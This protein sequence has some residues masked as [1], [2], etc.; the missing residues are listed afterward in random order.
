MSI[1]FILK[2]Y[3]A[4]S[5]KNEEGSTV[6]DGIISI[7]LLIVK[8]LA[9]NKVFVYSIPAPNFYKNFSGSTLD[10]KSLIAFYSAVLLK[11][12]IIVGPA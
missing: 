3:I 1:I 9:S 5:Y 11:A 8:V 7:S 2:N 6:P 10:T 4:L 12:T